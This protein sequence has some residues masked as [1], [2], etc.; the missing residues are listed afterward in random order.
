[1]LAKRFAL[2]FGI[3]VIF[4]MMLY[5]GVGS[6]SPPPHWQDY[7]VENFQE[8]HERGDLEEQQRLEAERLERRDRFLEHTRHFQK[9]LF[10][11]AVPIGIIAIIVGTFIALPAVGT[12]LLF[13]G[14]LSVT[15]GYLAYWTELP[16]SLRFVSLFISFVVLIVVGYKKLETRQP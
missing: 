10:F 11:V 16:E 13:G 5:Y 6:F 4:P 8:R 3:A 12:G 7:Q 2:G 9:L 1:M 15:T 14:I